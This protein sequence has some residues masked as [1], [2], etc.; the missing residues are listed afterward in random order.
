MEGED[1]LQEEDEENKD[2]ANSINDEDDDDEDAD[3]L[4]FVHTL[5]FYDYVCELQRNRW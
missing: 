3:G 2:D 1:V 5:V 4:C